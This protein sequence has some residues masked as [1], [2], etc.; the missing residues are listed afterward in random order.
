M[1][2]H[3]AGRLRGA[4]CRSYDDHRIAMSLAIAGLVSEGPMHI[5]GAG[6]ADISYP[7]FWRDLELVGGAIG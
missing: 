7:T 1:T 3:G 6:A 5:E 2:I 4:A